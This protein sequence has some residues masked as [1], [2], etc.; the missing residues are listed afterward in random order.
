MKFLDSVRGKIVVELAESTQFHSKDQGTLKAFITKSSDQYRKPYARRD[1]TFPRH[2]ILAA[3]SNLA[4]VFTDVTGNRRYYPIYC[5]PA[6]F[7]NR[8]Q[9]EVEQVW[10]EAYAMYQQGEVC[11]IRQDWYPATVVQYQATQDNNNVAIIDDWLDNPEHG[12]SMPGAKICEK[13]LYREM[14]HYSETDLIRPEHK[15]AVRAWKN[16]SKN[17]EQ[18]TPIKY[19]GKSERAVQRIHYPGE[20]TTELVTPKQTQDELYK[21]SLETSDMIPWSSKSKPLEDRFA[22]F[23]KEAQYEGS[24]VPEDLFSKSE[25]NHLVDLGFVYKVRNKDRYRILR[26]PEKI[27]SSIDDE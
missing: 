2:F 22:E 1:D 7:D 21:L 18:C 20:N 14:F 5:G 9:Y 15:I 10:A 23:C 19:N 8:T 12:Y 6:D 17:W 13:Q 27:I 11:R 26:F 24:L 3:S 16:G 25:L 4:D